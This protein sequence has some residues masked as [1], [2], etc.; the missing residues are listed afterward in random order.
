MKVNESFESSM[1]RLLESS[2]VPLGRPVVRS[3][4]S[5]KDKGVSEMVRFEQALA[6]ALRTFSVFL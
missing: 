1:K 2:E 5:E 4:N 3:F 6:D